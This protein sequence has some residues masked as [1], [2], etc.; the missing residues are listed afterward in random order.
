MPLAFSYKY[1][2]HTYAAKSYDM[3]PT[4]L[5]ASPPKEVVLRNL[6]AL[7]IVLGWV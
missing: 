7:P 6:I 3:G 4:A 2:F 1:L 5:L